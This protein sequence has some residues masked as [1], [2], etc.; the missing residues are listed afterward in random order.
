MPLKGLDYRHRIPTGDARPI[1]RT[2]YGT[3]QFQ[4]DWIRR[5]V[6]RMLQNGVIVP[7]ESAWAFPILLV[8]KR[9]GGQRLCNDYRDLNAITL[10]D[11]YPLLRI[12]DIMMMFKGRTV[13]SGMDLQCGFRQLLV[14]LMDRCKIAL[15][16]SWGCL[17]MS[18]CHSG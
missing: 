13:F 18:P 14:H 7:S 11:S 3:N 1:R 9:G 4:K 17:N 6:H 16:V 15:L 8:G 10:G 5:I 2:P 12:E